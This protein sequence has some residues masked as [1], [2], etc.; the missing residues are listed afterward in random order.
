MKEIEITQIPPLAPGQQSLLDFHSVVNVIN[1][2]Q[3]ELLVLGYLLASNDQLMARGLAHCDEVLASLTDHARALRHAAGIEELERAVFAEIAEKVAG[4]PPADAEYDEAMGNLRSVFAIL[5]VRARELL[6]R[7]EAPERWETFEVAALRQNFADVFAAIER[8][9]HGRYRILYNAALQQADD[10]YVDFKVES[11]DD[12]RLLMPPVLQDVMRDLIANARKYTKPGGHITAALHAGADGLRFVVRDDG[13]GIPVDEIP[14]VVEFGKR[15]SNVGEVRTMG[16]G[17]GL[18][19]A[20]LVT[21]QFG[22]RFWI[23]SRVGR[24]TRVRL[25]IPLP[26]AEAKAA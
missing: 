14:T 13:C 11:D 1:V 25:W 5:K 22:G 15:A 10:Y 26:A 9:S 8:N 16:G 21:K 17:F 6:A 7:A 4:R 20:F 3:G 18:T 2:L 24:G 19:K 12:G 23:A